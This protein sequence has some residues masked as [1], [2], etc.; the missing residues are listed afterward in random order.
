MDKPKPLESNDFIIF[1]EFDRMAPENMGRPMFF[2]MR[3]Y[4]AA[5]E[6]MICADELQL[7]LQ[8]INNPP[9]WYR[10]NLSPQLQDLKKKLYQNIYDQI[11][12]ATDNEEADC[13]REFGE[14]QWLGGMDEGYTFPRSTIITEAVE[15]LNGV[16]KIPWICDL[17]CSHGNLPLGLLKLGKRFSYRG[18]GMNHRIVEKLK[19]WVGEAWQDKPW[20]KQEAWLTCFEVIEHCMNPMDIVQSAYKIGVEFDRIYLSVPNGCLGHGLSNWKDR[21]MGHVRG[22]TAQEFLEFAQK[23][24]PGYSWTCYPAVS[25]VLEGFKK[26]GSD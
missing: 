1:D 5:I 8:M 21:R 6:M 16:E 19:G 10:Q 20:H 22:W 18:L 15:Q 7:A 23:N 11:E 2:D 25:I 12:Y 14:N 24:W 9:A 17:G 3:V 4:C 26:R 13:P